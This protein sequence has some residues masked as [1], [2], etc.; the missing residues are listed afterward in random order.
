[1]NLNFEEMLKDL[2]TKGFIK[3]EGVYAK[4]QINEVKKEYASV[5]NKF[6]DIQYDAEVGKECTNSTHHTI[7]MC[8]KMLKLLDPNPIHKFL[9]YYF[10]GKY[11]LYTMGASSK[12]P[13]SE[14]V[15][16]QRIHREFYTFTFGQRIM[17][18]TLIALDDATEE[19]AATWMLEGSHKLTQ[20]PS[21]EY[22]YKNAMQVT[23]KKGDVLIFDANIWHAAGVNKTDK[24][25]E[26]ITPLFTKPFI[27]QALNYPRAFGLDFQYTISDELKQ[28][29]GYNAIIPETIQEFYKPEER[30]FY[31]RNQEDEYGVNNPH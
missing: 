11:I 6:S 21:D 17:L 16:T 15:Y 29:L 12:M 10:N 8:P 9:E 18:N 24:P 25:V 3:V 19:G 31:K 1:M 26:I 13:H 4:E 28:T 23:A 22:F 30:R 20:N 2:D 5:K 27:K 14:Y 7:L